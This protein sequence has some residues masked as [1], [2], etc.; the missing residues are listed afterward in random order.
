MSV[1]KRS[2]ITTSIVILTILIVIVIIRHQHH[3]QRWVSARTGTVVNAIYGLG[4]VYSDQI[5]NL[6]FGVTKYINAIFVQQGQH[7]RKGDV[8]MRDEN[9]HKVRAPF[10]GTIT[11]KPYSSYETAT[12]QANILTLTN[13]HARYLQVSLD[14]DSFLQLQNAKQIRINFEALPKQTFDGTI[15]YRY[16]NDQ[17]FYLRVNIT[18]LPDNILPGMTA[19]TAIITHSAAHN[20][21]IPIASI[22]AGKV[23]YRLH[24]RI[25]TVA[26]T[27]GAVDKGWGAVSSH[28]IPATAKI[29]V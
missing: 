2:I 20:V 8:L 5:F 25:K 1:S 14:Q 26:V 19:D 6:H 21:Q 27:I 23:T 3:S 15:V 12:P 16:A 18:D 22:K 29:Q 4:T 9:N 13:M 17:N 24:D 11:A 7:V 10:S 28:N